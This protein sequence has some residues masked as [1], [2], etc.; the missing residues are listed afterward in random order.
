MTQYTESYS[1]CPTQIQSIVANDLKILDTY[2]LMQTGQYEWTCQIEE[3]GTHRTRQIKFTRPSSSY[4]SYYTVTRTDDVEFN[5]NIENEYYVYS[6]IGYGNS[7]DL[8][9]WKTTASF[10]L[11]II[12]CTLLFAIV[13]KG[14]LFKCLKRR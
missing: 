5:M 10:S 4:S 8:P 3:L 14:V 7:L 6:N 9:V 1:T 11:M 2:V 12:S 13:F